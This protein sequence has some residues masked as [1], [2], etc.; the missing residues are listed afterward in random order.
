MTIYKIQCNATEQS[1]VGSTMKGLNVRKNQHLSS[2]R[3]GAHV[4]FKLQQV[5]NEHGEDSLSFLV[6]EESNKSPRDREKHWM[7]KVRADRRL[8]IVERVHSSVAKN[9]IMFRPT[10][11]QESVIKDLIR[12]M[13]LSTIDN[14]ADAIKY[15]LDLG[16]A[17]HKSK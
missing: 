17:I 16:I 12:N 15:L 1:Y 3:R 8:N 2:L 5:F 13:K 10:S 9:C 14:K 4:N 7:D 6:L 11:A